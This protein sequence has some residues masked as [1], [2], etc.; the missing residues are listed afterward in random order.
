[1][2][3]ITYRKYG[4]PNEIL[5][6]GDIDPPVIQDDQVLVRVR[7]VSIQPLDWH[8]MTG[9]PYV[10]RLQLGLF[11][12]KRHRPG[13]DL[14]GTVEA[15][16]KNVTRF[17]VGD[18][19]F[20]ET[21]G[22]S[23]AELVAAP[24][25]TLVHKPGN[26]TFEQAAAVPVAGLTALQGLRDSGQIRPGHQVLVIGASGG[27]G[28][29]AVQIAKALGANVTAVCS[30]RNVDQ[31]RA[32]G[33]DHVID[34]T[35]DDFLGEDRRYDLILDI[36][37]TRG[38]FELGRVLQ[39]E[40]RYVVIGGRKGR[41]VRPLPRMFGAMLVSRIIGKKMVLGQET[42]NRADLELL[43][44]LLES[45]KVTPVIDRTY[46]LIDTLDAVSY[47]AEGHARGKIVV[48]V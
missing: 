12:P 31:A 9:T 27:V 42:A 46:P 14:A 48:T 25:E 15:V 22:G 30:T 26:V 32:I 35:K 17:R 33:A 21:I 13:A 6:F 20:G 3:A 8:L 2:K 41:W 24:E 1:M 40:G 39:P 28:T 16:G 47:L 37:G 38:L 7:A 45:G 23:C 11:G 10:V 44:E 43:K 18:D 34:Y 29:F 36:A 5:E 19:V 4:D